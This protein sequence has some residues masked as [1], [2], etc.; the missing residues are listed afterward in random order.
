M[1]T[2]VTATATAIETAAATVAGITVA[3]AA[4]ATTATTDT[5]PLA[6]DID[7]SLSSTA[8]PMNLEFPINLNDSEQFLPQT[9]MDA[10][11][12]TRL[13]CCIC[14]RESEYDRFEAVLQTTAIHESRKNSIRRRFLHLL[15]EYST[16]VWI[17]TFIYYMG[18]MVIT[19]GSL[20]VPALMA[21]QYTSTLSSSY[22]ELIYWITWTISLMVT[23]FNAILVLFK[24]DKKY[25]SLHTTLERLRSEGWQ[26]L[27]LTGRYSGVLTHYK[28]P[29]THI[30]QYR[31]FCHY[32]EKIKLK[33]IED[34]YYKYED[35]GNTMG[36]MYSGSA[37]SATPN[38][39]TGAAAPSKD[40]PMYPPSLS[41][42]MN[43]LSR[44]VPLSVQDAM[45]G[46]LKTPSSPLNRQDVKKPANIIIS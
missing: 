11:P 2:D 25:Y 35:G 41:K 28:E 21:I 39:T 46:L 43:T 20:I 40:V 34:E 8:V 44:N 38:N 23:A 36:T 14:C 32:V 5:K 10:H 16:R 30:N 7:L 27:E 26:Y 18:H 33:Q 24:V 3:T 6:T 17:Y 1:S 37:G 29:P 22:Q 19:V 4:T 31:F 45:Q 9:L 12:L 42:D 13:S 15:A